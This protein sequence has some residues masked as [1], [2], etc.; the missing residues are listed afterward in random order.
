M[1]KNV[2]FLIILISTIFILIG[3][4]SFN[5]FSKFRG[6]EARIFGCSG[7]KAGEWIPQ[8]GECPGSTPELQQKCNDFCEKHPDCCNRN[9]DG[10]NFGGRSNIPLPERKDIAELTRNYPSV[11]KAINEGPAI[12][13]QGQF[14]IISDETLDKMKEIGFNTIQLL[15]IDDCS[16]EKCVMDESSK[17]ILLNDIVRAKKKGMAVW[18]AVEYVNGPPGSN[19]KLPEYSKFKNSFIEYSKEIGELMEKY[20]VEYITVNNEPDLFL[21]EQT[22]WGSEEQINKYVSEIMPFANA[23][24]KEKFNGKVINKIT[25]INKRTKDVLNAS[26]INVDIASVD[27]GPP[28][29][30]QIGLEGYKKDFEQYQIYATLAQQKNVSWM[31]G[32]YWT[33]NYFADANQF[34]KD[35]QVKLAQISFDAYLNTTPKGMGYAWNDFSS[36]SL[37]NGE[38]TRIAL[39][40][41]L[42]KI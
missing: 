33:F 24:V 30:A 27:V 21:Q 13:G 35:N 23:A 19:I 11:I 1:K 41:F 31:V 7:L 10:G 5:Y 9:Q 34:V 29:S 26:F 20:E 36:F 42:N 37:P 16:G 40:E 22:Q 18:V 12:Y 3:F 28:A 38:E 14:K 39:K 32:E 17:S 25:Q 15:T 6:E 4:F 8:K 2:I